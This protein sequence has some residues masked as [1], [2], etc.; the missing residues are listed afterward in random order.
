MVDSTKWQMPGTERTGK[1]LVP[2]CA[3]RGRVGFRLL[4]AGRSVRVR[5]EPANQ[6]ASDR[7]A[8]KLTRAGGW[9]QPGDDG[10]DRFSKVFTDQKSAIKAVK[11]AIRLLGRRGRKYNG[12]LGRWSWRKPITDHFTPPTGGTKSSPINGELA[13]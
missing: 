2:V 6:A 5:I 1:Y 4:G 8:V 10:Q 11:Q 3:K 7:L 9:K 13:A 12:S